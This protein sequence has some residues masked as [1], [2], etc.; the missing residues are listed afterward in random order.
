MGKVYGKGGEDRADKLSFAGEDS[1]WLDDEVALRKAAVFPTEEFNRDHMPLIN[2][3]SFRSFLE[4]SPT[5]P[6][7]LSTTL[8]LAW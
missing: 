8:T 7:L 1:D 2:E 5:A 6:A 4:V 3:S